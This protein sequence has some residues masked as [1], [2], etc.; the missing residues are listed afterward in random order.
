MKMIKSQWVGLFI[1]LVLLAFSLLGIV[2]SPHSISQQDL[3]AIMEP[4]SA[5]HWLGTDHFGRSMMT[6]MAHAIGLSFALSVLCV[7]TS[8]LVGTTFGVWAVWGGKKVD[9][10]LNVMVNILLALPGLVV[11]LLLAAIVPGSFLMLYLAISLVQWVEYFRVVRAVTQGVIQSPARQSSEM[12]GFGR[13]YQFKRH[14]WPAISP[15][16]FTLAAFGGA[17]AILTMASLGFVYVGIQ[18]PMAELG[19]MT[20]EL[21]PYYSEAPWLL[22]LPLMVIALLVFSFHLLAGKRA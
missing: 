4:P 3:N 15:S 1:L 22:A 18:P 7:L 14:I 9:S 20:V 5:A 19:L 13:W 17:N 10:A 21:F 11:V 6:R 2:F 12:M 16:V 8:S